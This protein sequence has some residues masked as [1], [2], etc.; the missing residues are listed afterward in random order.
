MSAN[1]YP[2]VVHPRG[3]EHL[4]A[5]RR[6]LFPVFEYE[7]G[8]G[9]L[10]KTVAAVHGENTT[11]VV[12][13]LAEGS[14][15]AALELRPLLTWRDYHALGPGA[16]LSQEAVF[17]NDVLRI[18]QPPEV[19]FRAPRAGFDSRSDLYHRFR[20]EMER[21]RG[22]DFEEDLWTPGRLVRELAPGERLGIVIS[23]SDPRGRDACELLE[24][25]RQH[26]EG[27]LARLPAQDDL[28]RALGLAADQF[29]V[30]RGEGFRTLI[31]GYHWL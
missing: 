8:A 21:R 1:R 26:R 23:A 18:S 19:F 29:V 16:V 6:G 25:E 12:Y 11:L 20:Y 27:I 10:R 13:E 17:E 31:A 30:R 5:F 14:A 7:A 9:R 24:Q 22:L 3:F 28:T 2:G 4:A 15:P